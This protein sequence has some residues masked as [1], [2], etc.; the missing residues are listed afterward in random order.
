MR[1]P[2]YRFLES[3]PD[4]FIVGEINEV[5]SLLC[6]KLAVQAGTKG[7]YIGEKTSFKVNQFRTITESWIKL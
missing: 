4:G 1:I 2:L 3:R 7:L 6:L 5:M